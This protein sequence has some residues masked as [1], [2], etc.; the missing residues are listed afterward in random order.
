MKLP[1]V[2]HKANTALHLILSFVDQA[3]EEGLEKFI[4]GHLGPLCMDME[5]TARYHQAIKAQALGEG[6][7]AHR[8]E[9]L[10]NCPLGDDKLAGSICIHSLRQKY[11]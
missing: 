6:L 10:L 7:Q 9:K 8:L 2:Q 5:K 3:T 4:W 1:P 11:G